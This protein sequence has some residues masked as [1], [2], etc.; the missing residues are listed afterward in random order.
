MAHLKQ[1]FVTSQEI[2]GFQEDGRTPQ[3]SLGGWR[4][5]RINPLIVI[6]H[7]LGSEHLIC[8]I[9]FK[10]TWHHYE[11]NYLPEASCGLWRRGALLMK[12]SV[13]WT[14]GL[15]Q[16]VDL[17]NIILGHVTILRN[18]GV[19]VPFGVQVMPQKPCFQRVYQ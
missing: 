11:G 5:V 2:F 7:S 16:I 8:S 3:Q 10:L 19:L 14:V 17:K 9:Y 13:G 12:I 1:S 4:L 6:L 15:L 18:S